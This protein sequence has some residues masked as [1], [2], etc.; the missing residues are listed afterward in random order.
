MLTLW[1]AIVAYL[2]ANAA[3]F[4]CTAAQVVAGEFGAVP[5]AP[6]AVLVFLLPAAPGTGTAT[7]Y[8]VEHYGYSLEVFVLGAPAASQQEGIC[9]VTDKAATIMRL[10]AEAFSPR[11]PGPPIDLDSVDP[12]QPIASV[13][14]VVFDNS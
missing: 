9:D 8:S 10:L 1:N 4:G 3:A 6:P 5:L 14:C 11:W 13:S 2:Q 7:G 12:T